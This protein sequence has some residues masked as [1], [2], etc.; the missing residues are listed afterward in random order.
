MP[1]PPA[2]T[3]DFSSTG[4]NLPFTLLQALCSATGSVACCRVSAALPPPTVLPQPIEWIKSRQ[5]N[6]NNKRHATQMPCKVYPKQLV[7]STTTSLIIKQIITRGTWGFAVLRCCAVDVNAVTRW[8]KSQLS[9]LRWSQALWC[10]MFVFFTLRWSV[11]WN[12]LR[13]WGFL[14]DLFQT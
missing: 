2:Q 3:M 5:K 13:C 6:Q 8:I 14:Y 4:A 9:V 7:E 12:Y 10:A 11:K 1:W